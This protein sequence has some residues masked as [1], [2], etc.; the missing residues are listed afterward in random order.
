MINVTKI[1]E[2]D[3]RSDPKRSEKGS[4]CPPLK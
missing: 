3:F 4:N 2:R 1:V